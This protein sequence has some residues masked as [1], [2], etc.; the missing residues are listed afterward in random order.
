[1]TI[2]ASALEWDN[3]TNQ[4]TLEFV[5][6]AYHGVLDGGHTLRAILDLRA[7]DG[8]EAEQAYCN[9]ELFTGLDEDDIPN[10]VEARNTSKQVVSKSLMNLDG[11][12]DAFKEAIGK[13]NADLIS[14]KENES[15][16]FDVREFIGILTALD[17]D[18]YTGN[19][20]PIP[21]YTGK[22]ACL[23][24]FSSP[25]YQASYNKLLGIAPDALTIWD[26]IQYWLPSQ[27]NQKGPEPGVSGKFGRLTGVKTS[28]KKKRRLPFIG[29]ETE[30]DI[31][32]GYIYPILSAFRA[33]LVEENGRW[34]WG[35]GLA[36]MQLIKQGLATDIFISSVRD[37]INVHRNANRT[38]KDNQAWNAAYQAARIFYLE[39]V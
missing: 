2:V 34:V 10:V 1:M 18:S 22:E 31:P 33:M 4:L 16:D 12:F 15:A 13:Q 23:K 35:K 36:P 38:G 3:K 30:Y 20:H 5:D 17:A 21:A 8:Q 25:D 27:Y 37:S 19:H 28:P 11:R 32:T 24:R 6:K 14:W 29:Q 26:G 39:Q 7:T 9:I